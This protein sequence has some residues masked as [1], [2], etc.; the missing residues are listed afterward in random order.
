MCRVRSAFQRGVFHQ[1]PTYT[2][3]SSR[4]TVLFPA[5]YLPRGKIPRGFRG[6]SRRSYRNSTDTRVAL[7]TLPKNFARC[8]G[9]VGWRGGLSCSSQ[10]V[11]TAEYNLCTPL[12]SVVK[13]QKTPATIFGGY[14]KSRHFSA[15]QPFLRFF[16]TM[17]PPSTTISALGSLYTHPSPPF[18][19][20]FCQPPPP[21]V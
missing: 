2:H 13:R 5:R 14:K 4:C 3:D 21:H 20:M 18:Y 19:V 10:A 1:D 8:R 17:S 15:R 16:L 7:L 9:L 6:C 12:P 11:D